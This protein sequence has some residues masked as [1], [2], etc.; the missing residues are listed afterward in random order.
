MKSTRQGTRRVRWGR[1]GHRR[2]RIDILAVLIQRLRTET[3]QAAQSDEHKRRLRELAIALVLS[4]LYDNTPR[5]VYMGGWV[6]QMYQTYRSNLLNRLLH[7]LT[8]GVHNE[9]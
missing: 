9:R 7:K 3:A 5:T 6:G 2:S 8:Q 4:M 1:Q